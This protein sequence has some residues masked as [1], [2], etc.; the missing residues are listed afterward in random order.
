MKAGNQVC[1]IQQAK[2]LK[3]IG[4][5]Q[6]AYFS[7]QHYPPTI[8]RIESEEIVNPLVKE[9]ATDAGEWFS[10]FNISELAKMIEGGSY[11]AERLW[12]RMLSRINGG[13]SCVSFYDADF[14]A[15]F[16]IEILEAKY[17]S[18]EACNKRL[19]CLV[20]K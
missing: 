2:K 11:E 18:V 14:L 17:L 3:G 12:N 19:L 7:H 1:S 4:V 16:L 9:C 15:D 10:A 20:L 13:N 6:V 8:Y 5:V